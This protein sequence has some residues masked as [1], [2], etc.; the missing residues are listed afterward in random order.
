MAVRISSARQCASCTL[1]RSER[2]ITTRVYEH[3]HIWQV[4]ALPRLLWMAPIPART[5]LLL[6][7]GLPCCRN[8]GLHVFHVTVMALSWK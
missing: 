3:G 7:L 6:F 1:Q 5:G 2:D 8:A 4:Q